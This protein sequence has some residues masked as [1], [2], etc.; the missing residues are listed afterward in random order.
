M[1]FNKVSR[2]PCTLHHDI[3][4]LNIFSICI[5][6]V[7]A[8]S[9]PF[10]ETFHMLL[11]QVCPSTYSLPEPMNLIKSKTCENRPFSKR[12]KNCFSRPIIALQVKSIAEC[13]KHSA[14]LS[15]FIK[16]QFVIKIFIL[17][18]FEWRFYTGFTVH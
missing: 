5:V 2:N 9:T 6:L 1:P 7:T 12:Q 4:N 3:D 13:S 18:I 14:I 10:F 8:L 16:L 11:P 15:T 17:S